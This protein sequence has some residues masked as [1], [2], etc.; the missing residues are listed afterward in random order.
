MEQGMVGNGGG[1]W[2]FLALSEHITLPD[3]LPILKVLP[4]PFS[5]AFMEGP[6]W[7]QID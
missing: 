5:R 4:T 3:V 2:S 1:A 6:L 7:R